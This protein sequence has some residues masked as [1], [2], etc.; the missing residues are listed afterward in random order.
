MRYIERLPLPPD[1]VRGLA[2]RQ[3]RVD[4]LKASGTLEPIKEWD[5]GRKLKS[6]KTAHAVLRRM[7]GETERCMYCQDSHGTDIE[8]FKPKARFP[9][10]MYHWENMLLCCT[11]CGRFK[12]EEYPCTRDGSPLLIDPSKE[13]PWEYLDFEQ[14]TG[15]ITARYSRDRNEYSPKG[16]ETVKILHL[17]RRGALSSLYRKSNKTLVEKVYTLI[18]VTIKDV[19]EEASKLIDIDFAGLLGW[20]IHGS[21]IHEDPFP[22]LKERQPLLWE[23]LDRKIGRPDG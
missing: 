18:G 7:A 15:N 4:R 1:T 16:I 10:T 17:D 6:V 8:H 13:D 11:E 20:Y 22:L 9:G 3:E 23:A 2:V 5:S 14:R 19:E 12:G 21:G